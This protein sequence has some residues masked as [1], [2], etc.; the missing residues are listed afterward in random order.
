MKKRHECLQPFSRDHG[1]A[2]VYAQKCRKAVRASEFDRAELADSIRDV[3]ARVI[4]SNLED[5]SQV[6]SPLINKN[7]M[8]R[9]FHRHHH[10]IRKMTY[11][12]SLLETTLDPGL[13]VVSRIANALDD[14]VRWMENLLFPEIE[15]S[16]NHTQSE[17]LA[18]ATGFI[19]ANRMRPTQMLHASIALRLT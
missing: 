16:L 1:F 14:Y 18:E 7:G 2:L 15:R 4:L 12:L 10:D 17:A 11:E 13:C 9:D 19:E 8:R 5:E 6:L 3:V